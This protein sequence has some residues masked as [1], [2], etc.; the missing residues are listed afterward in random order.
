MADLAA[1]SIR[2][3]ASFE[4]RLVLQAPSGNPADL[5]GATARLRCFS[6]PNNA[7]VF[8]EVPATITVPTAEIL[9]S[10]SAQATGALSAQTGT[11]AVDLTLPGG[12]VE[13]LAEGPADVLNAGQVPPRRQS[14]LFAQAGTDGTNALL[15]Q[16]RN[17]V[18]PLRTVE[19]PGLNDT[20]PP[21]VQ[22]TAPQSGTVSGNVLIQAAAADNDQIDRVVFWVDGLQV[23]TAYAAPYQTTWN[24][25]Q[26]SQGAK[27]LRAVAY[28]RSGNQASSADVVVVVSN[29]TATQPANLTPPVIS[30]NAYDGQTLTSSA[31]TWSGSPAPT[32]TYQ[33]LRNGSNVAGATSATYIVGTADLNAQI[34]CAVTATNTAGSATATS[35]AVGPVTSQPVAPTNTALPAITGTA[36]V[37]QQ[38]TASTGTW[39]ATPAA[40]FAYQWTRGGTPIAGATS[41]A[42]TLTGADAGATIAVAVTAQNSAGSATA[43]SGTVGPVAQPPTNSVAPVIS[44]N[45]IVGQLLTTSNGTWAGT[46]SPSFTYQWRRNGTPISGATG[47][48]YTVQTADIGAS[49]TVAVT[50]TNSAGTGNAISAGVSA[51]ADLRPR[52]ALGPATFADQAAINAFAATMTIATQKWNGSALVSTAN[53]DRAAQFAAAT[54]GNAAGTAYVWYAATSAALVAEPQ[55][56]DSNSSFAF[57]GPWDAVTGVTATI[58]G[59]VY[60]LRRSSFPNAFPAGTQIRSA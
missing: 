1:I 39:T 14:G 36:T 20:I 27:T 53:N 43:N 12:A 42:Y 25:A 32:L 24:T 50:A 11:F 57:S 9:F 37:G 59:T 55:F 51:T 16:Q 45:P 5:S 47:A 26:L 10:A 15:I 54:A 29:T 60:G 6:G 13:R 19:L 30:G 28:D 7:I 18:I 58:N 8:F 22:L 33:W 48:T 40:T 2:K 17:T 35:A 34:T 4:L 44:G 52:F 49:L 56:S 21:T 31:G 38:L 41:N 46:P 3:G 23:G